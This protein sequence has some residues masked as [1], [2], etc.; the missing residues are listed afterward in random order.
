[1]TTLQVLS[2]YLEEL[3][4]SSQFSDYCPNGLQVEG[5]EKI[6]RIAT[7]V[8][9]SLSTIEAAAKCEAH[10]LIVHHGLFW[11]RD[12]YCVTGSKRKKLRILLEKEIS[13]F[14]FHLPL[15][16]HCEVGNNWHAARELGWKNLEPF[17][18]Y[19]GIPIGVKG[20]F[21]AI[22]VGQFTKS[23]EEYYQ[24]QAITALGGK[25]TVQT[26]ALI[27]GGAHRN[28]SD[29]VQEELDCYVT[30]TSDEPIWHIAE[31]EAINFFALGHSATERI[32][33]RA[34]GRLLSKKFGIQEEFLDIPNPF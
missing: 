19:N 33:V 32:G 29:A 23:L 17:G 20:T 28:I 15:D 14:A 13:L 4:H 22:P 6:E 7:G 24:H 26:A 9:A 8:S 30:G 10:A 5:R 25:K 16:A 18:N 3:L 31:E 2:N 34:L 21:D 27:S 1:M 12:D 11:N